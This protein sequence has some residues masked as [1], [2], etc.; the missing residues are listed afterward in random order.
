[1]IF[2][3]WV[4]IAY[5]TFAHAFIGT[6]KIPRAMS[7]PSREQLKAFLQNLIVSLVDNRSLKRAMFPLVSFFIIYFIWLAWVLV[8]TNKMAFIWFPL[9]A[10]NAIKFDTQLRP[11]LFDFLFFYFI[12]LWPS[13]RQ[14]PISKVENLT[15]FCQMRRQGWT[16][17]VL[18]SHMC[19]WIYNLIDWNPEIQWM[20]PTCLVFI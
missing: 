5:S 20:Q 11:F 9:D 10:A 13:M 1:M 16:S 19:R 6:D 18:T 15:F 8:P 2:F 14:W 12:L 4:K 17:L 7:N 3:I